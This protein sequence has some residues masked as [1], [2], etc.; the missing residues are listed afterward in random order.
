MSVIVEVEELVTQRLALLN[1]DPEAGHAIMDDMTERVV[2]ALADGD[3]TARD[4][5]IR[6]T[7]LLDIEA[8]RGWTRWYS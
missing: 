8:R 2:R 1:A 4:A 5:A 7:A 6:V 3:V